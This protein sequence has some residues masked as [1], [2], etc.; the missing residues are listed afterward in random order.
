MSKRKLI[1]IK[2]PEIWYSII[3]NKYSK[4]HNHL[5]SFDK[6]ELKRFLPR[7]ID[8]F[9]ILDLWAWDW[10]LYKFFSNKN[11]KYFA[12]DICEDILDLHP[13][14]SRVK[15]Q[16]FDLNL[17]FPLESDYFDLWL[18][19]FV[20]EHLYDLQN[21]F[22]ESYRVLKKWS[23]I[24]IWYFHQRRERIRKDLD[25]KDF[26]IDSKY[27]RIEDIKKIMEYN[28]FSFKIFP[29]FE[30]WVEIWHIIIGQK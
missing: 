26:K 12:C 22:S 9:N 19:Y 18:S 30:R 8:N 4:Y 11:I 23:K 27:R 24:L 6:W 1:P 21:F 15:K 7:N 3:C 14:W 20:I 10:R 5:D 28:F 25:N 16:I 2:S 13:S 17:K 29:I